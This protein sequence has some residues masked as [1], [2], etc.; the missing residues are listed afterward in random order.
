MMMSAKALLLPA[1][2]VAGLIFEAL[3]FSVSVSVPTTGC[4]TA[5]DSDA[6]PIGAQTSVC[7]GGGGTCADSTSC[8]IAAGSACDSDFE[9]C[10][11]ACSGGI[12]VTNSTNPNCKAELGSRCESGG[13]QCA[14]DT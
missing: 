14:S 11:G 9:C 12:C 10:S 8:C 1:G 13:C 7:C 2:F 6:G 3:A 4:Q 5:G